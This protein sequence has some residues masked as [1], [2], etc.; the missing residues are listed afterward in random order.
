[1]AR[2]L[3]VGALL[4]LCGC[5]PPPPPPP[6]PPPL[7]PQARPAPT[8]TPEP[9]APTPPRD[10]PQPYPEPRATGEG[11]PFAAGPLAGPREG[12]LGD[13]ERGVFHVARWPRELV[14]LAPET[15]EVVYR[16]A[17]GEAPLLV[18]GNRLL[19]VGEGALWILDTQDGAAVFELPLPCLPP[20]DD[21]AFEPSAV[22][23]EGH[24]GS[25][26]VVLVHVERAVA[27][28]RVDPDAPDRE[29]ALRRAGEAFAAAQAEAQAAAVTYRFAVDVEAGRVVECPDRRACEHVEWNTTVGPV[30]I[31]MRSQYYGRAKG[32]GQ[33]WAVRAR[34]LFAS[35]PTPPEPTPPLPPPWPEPEAQ[36]EVPAFSAGL[37]YGQSGRGAL[38]DPQRGVYHLLL[39]DALV[40]VEPETGERVY[41][42]AQEGVPLAVLGDRLVVR[43]EGALWILD[44]RDGAAVF[45]VASPHFPPLAEEAGRY[46]RIQATHA[47]GSQVRL[48]VSWVEPAPPDPD[49]VERAPSYAFG[50]DVASGALLA[51]PTLPEEQRL[52]AAEEVGP[53]PAGHAQLDRAGRRRGEFRGTRCGSSEVRDLSY[54][55]PL[56]VEAD[57]PPR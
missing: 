47:Q 19:A 57:D 46:G 18:V 6:A 27:W 10:L 15:G 23:V 17:A 8:P 56:K 20:L 29:A 3:A 37:R 33:D 54:R 28:E 39:E 30:G 52:L 31:G 5:E 24:V 45:R 9:P 36:G 16:H 44:T 34:R 32:G 38:A 21:P 55:E 11:A 13:V 7:P 49:A 48:E 12:I 4:A 42:H 35:V 14:A 43:G 53:L 1:M 26:V 22:G 51:P 25:V 50:L 2:W 41:A 40:A